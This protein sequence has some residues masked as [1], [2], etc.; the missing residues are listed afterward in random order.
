MIFYLYIFFTRVIRVDTYLH[1]AIRVPVFDEL[2]C[3][4]IVV[5]TKAAHCLLTFMGLI[6][7]SYVTCSHQHVAVF[8]GIEIHVFLILLNAGFVVF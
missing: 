8:Y 5:G 3:E 7:T 4:S 1:A 2:S 6:I